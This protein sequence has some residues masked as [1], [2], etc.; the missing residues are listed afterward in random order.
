MPVNKILKLQRSKKAMIRPLT[1]KKYVPME[2]RDS[3]KNFIN[4]MNQYK[5]FRI[6]LNILLD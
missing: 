1:T 6:H 4:K 5:K 3:Y 2:R